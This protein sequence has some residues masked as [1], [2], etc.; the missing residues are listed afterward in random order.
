M[1]LLACARR[2]RQLGPRHAQL[3]HCV[4]RDVKLE[5]SLVVKLENS[6]VETLDCK[7]ILKVTDWGLAKLDEESAC[8]SDVG[9]PGYVGAVLKPSC[10]AGQPLGA[11][12]QVVWTVLGL[13]LQPAGMWPLLQ[14]DRGLTGFPL[15]P[16]RC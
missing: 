14:V 13:Q 2:A 15:Q 12:L 16:Q 5:N 6:L 3:R 11:Q 8:K 4:C 1:P 9:T 10:D 7:W